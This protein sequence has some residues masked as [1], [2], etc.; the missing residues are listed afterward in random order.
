MKL[1]TY[2]NHSHDVNEIDSVSSESKM[3]LHYARAS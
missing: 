2:T 3:K 1:K